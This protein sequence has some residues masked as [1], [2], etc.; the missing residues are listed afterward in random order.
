MTGQ[1]RRLRTLRRGQYRSMSVIQPLFQPG[2]VVSVVSH[3]HGDMVH[4][5]LL[6][7]A[8]V[9]AASISRVVLTQNLPEPEP[10]PP[11]GGWPFELLRVV[12]E[13]P[14]GFG[15]NHNRA[16]ATVTE[17]FVCVLNPDVMLVG[18]E[19]PFQVLVS[20]CC[21]SNIGCA[22]PVQIDPEGRVQGSER[23]VPSPVALLRRRLMG[24]QE[25]RVDWV[26]AACMVLPSAVWRSLGGF[27]ERYFMYC[28]DVDLCLRLR[29][30]GLHLAKAPVRV[31]HAGQRASSRSLKHLGW[32][33]QSLW[34]L[35]HSPVYAR[36]LQF[37]TSASAGKGTIGAP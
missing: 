16:L 14:L 6:Q 2:L 23:E 24:R 11:A 32:H 13:A 3:G 31:I 1:I 22:Y 25:I 33:V 28:E 20:A 35:W 15:A 17:P 8:R 21:A 7:L 34:R 4:A 37:L 30:R 26:N 36:A 5:L 29:L 18:H 9:S 27:D 12:N 19:D 10:V